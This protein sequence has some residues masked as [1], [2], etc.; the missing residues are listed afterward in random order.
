MPAPIIVLL[1]ILLVAYNNCDNLA[2]VDE[3]SDNGL[4]GRDY[5]ENSVTPAFEQ[6]CST[7]HSAPRFGGVAPMTIF[8]Y[9]LAKE[10]LSNGTSSTD[11]EL[12]NK[13]Q[14]IISHSG[15]NVCLSG[16]N[17]SPC[18]EVRQWW[19]LEFSGGSGQT[20]L[21]GGVSYMSPLGAMTGWAAQAETPDVSLEVRFYVGGPSG[22]G[23][24][25]DTVTANENSGGAGGV[26][27][28]HGFSFDIPSAYRDGTS[29]DLYIYAIID[30]SE[31]IL[32]GQPYNFAAYEASSAGM[33]Y[34]T[35]TVASELNSSCGSCHGF[36]ADH[37]TSFL[38]LLNPTPA[39]GGTATNNELYNKG[40]GQGHSAG[41]RC[42]SSCRSALQNWWDTEF[43]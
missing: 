33:S 29:R 15:S 38:T 18:Y 26:A 27:G 4:A 41:N 9:D 43:N 25:L 20:G 37:T 28:L 34:F 13:M 19:S 39:N 11:N 3:G 36:G 32:P 31:V 24:L 42:G 35:S 1:T 12:I 2:Q 5:Y 10:K 7:C 21:L 22:S 14:N 23:T 8:S 17:A 16:V 6:A 40:T 30:G